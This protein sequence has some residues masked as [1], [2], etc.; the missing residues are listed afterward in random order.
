MTRTFIL[1][2]PLDPEQLKFVQMHGREALSEVFE[3]DLQCVS[4]TDEI[5]ATDL[6]GQ[7]VTV[8]V[9]TQDGSSRYLNGIVSE[10]GYIGPDGSAARR[11]KYEMKLRSWLWLADKTS[12]CRNFQEMDVP[13]IIRTVLAEF[14]MPFEIKIMDQYL[15]RDYVVQYQ[16]TA[17]NFVKRLAEEVG[18]YFYVR[19]DANSHTI[20]FTD[21]SHGTLPE[22]AKIPFLTPSLRTLDAEEYVK[23][24]KTQHEVRS[25]R[26]VTTS[27]DFKSPG[28]NLLRTDGAPKGHT[29]D[30][31]EVFE[32]SG[33]YTDRDDGAKRA[34]VRS[35]QQQQDFKTIKAASNVRGIAPGYYFSLTN[36]PS[37]SANIEYLIVS[38]DYFFQENSDSTNSQEQKTQWDIHFTA[39]PSSERYQ[40]PCV[41]TKPRI[42]GPQTALVTGPGGQETWVNEYGQIKVRFYWD[43]YSSKDQSSSCWVRVA[44][45]WAGSN[46]GELMVPRIG[47]EVI[48]EH[49]DGDPDR[50]IV[51]GRVNNAGQMPTSF[52]KQGGL[53]SNQALAG[54]KSKEFQ[55]NRY[56]QLLFD[57]TTGEIRAQL[58]SEHAKS[59]LNLGYLTHPRNGTATPRGEGFELRTDAWGSLRAANGLLLSTDARHGAEGGALSREELITTLQQA[60]DLARNLGKFAEQNQANPSDLKPQ[61]ALSDALRNLGHGSNSEQ[62][63]NAG[64]PILAMSGKGGLGIGSPKDITIASSQHIDHVAQQNQH[65]T[66][67]EQ[68]N[69]QAGKGISQFAMDGGIKSIANKGKHITMAQND[70]IQITADQSVE[71]S[72][73][74]NHVLVTADKHITLMCGGG[75]I[76]IADGNI[77]IH[78][79]G[80]LDMK[81]GNYTMQGPDSAWITDKSK[82]PY[83]GQYKLVSDNGPVAQHPY[84]LTMPD[85]TKHYGE[86]GTDGKTMKVGSMDPK[87]IKLTVMDKEKWGQQNINVWQ[88]EIEDLWE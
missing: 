55:G 11:Y 72:A 23:E 9:I 29:S 67:G 52:S 17:L 83:A 43:R 2:T 45:S 54:L 20:V 59:Q 87:D 56:N 33:A 18:L 1:H 35:E 14:E 82:A 64:Q 10:F 81:A 8:E 51:V 69:M 75:F 37:R 28:A 57:D 38:A 84:I 49:L 42:I 6:L 24:W 31:Y 26:F 58:E 88:H 50:P 44:S 15:K 36:H 13:T 74:H 34:R 62:G 68:M 80:T 4:P 66:A 30:S 5:D 60:L 3:F 21:G 12:D 61:T 16:E 22:Y 86:T 70:D 41:T 63:E 7:S 85:G 19:H 25:G 40:P 76:K 73:S 53:P 78:C 27:Y 32:W 79:P 39:K 47:Q 65:L 77:Q 71:I 48:V 46:W